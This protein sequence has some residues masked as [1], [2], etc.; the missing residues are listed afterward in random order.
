MSKITTEDCRT[1]ISDWLLQNAALE[2]WKKAGLGYLAMRENWKR[3]SKEM[4][5]GEVV[6]SFTN[7][8]T[9]LAS[10]DASVEC[11]ET[12]SGNLIVRVD[13]VSQPPGFLQ[14]LAIK[15]AP[16]PEPDRG[17]DFGSW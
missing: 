10:M 7:T 1:A 9:G 17:Q 15:M 3:R 8:E 5:N 2:E 6:R 4:R 12:K 14:T 11:V 13:A 16:E